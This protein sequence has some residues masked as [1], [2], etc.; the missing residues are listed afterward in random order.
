MGK[1]QKEIS[2]Y[3]TLI[4]EQKSSPEDVVALKLGRK[5]LPEFTRKVSQRFNKVLYYTIQGDIKIILTPTN[6]GGVYANFYIGNNPNAIA[7]GV[8]VKNTETPIDGL[9]IDDDND[10]VRIGN[11]VINNIYGFD[12]LIEFANKSEK[13]E[14]KKN[15]VVDTEKPK[16]NNEKTQQPKTKGQ[17]PKVKINTDQYHIPKIKT[18]LN[19]N[20]RVIDKFNKAFFNAKTKIGRSFRKDVNETNIIVGNMTGGRAI[21]AFSD[22]NLSSNEIHDAITLASN[23]SNKRKNIFKRKNTKKIE[24]VRKIV[25][26]SNFNDNIVIFVS[27]DKKIPRELPID[28]LL[29]NVVKSEGINDDDAGIILDSVVK[30]VEIKNPKGGPYYISTYKINEDWLHVLTEFF[31]TTKL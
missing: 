7:T 13:I 17:Q 26:N 15:D 22:D 6:K 5:G 28:L 11:I 4:N 2:K 3:K 21:L 29:K 30:P 27:T 14:T 9:E 8:R 18:Y 19:N 25:E 10:N 16:N 20:P 12:Q 24:S 31:V 23:L 1:L